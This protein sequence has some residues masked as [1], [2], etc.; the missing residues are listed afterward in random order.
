[1]R[2]S[3]L[4]VALL[5]VS[6]PVFGQIDKKAEKELLVSYQKVVTALKKKDVK[7]VM[8]MMT[9]DAT[10]T[11]MGQTMNRAQ[12]EQMLKQS[13]GMMEF[14]SMSVKF[15]KVVVKRDIADT[16]YTEIAKSK[17][18][19]PDGKVSMTEMVSKYKTTF[20]KIGND[21]KM[22]A[23]TTL[24]QPEMKVDGKK[25]TLPKQP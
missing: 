18:K 20:Q 19:G 2:K 17:I 22:K 24:G 9:P 14:E 12:F 16:E 13:L 1:M 6:L 10:A 4:A 3:I 11:E 5:V 23:S 7:A 21:W 8:S 15:T 25:T